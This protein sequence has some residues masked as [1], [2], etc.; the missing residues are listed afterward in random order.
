MYNMGKGGATQ[1]ELCC[2]LGDHTHGMSNALCSGWDSLPSKSYKQN[3]LYTEQ[4]K[5]RIAFAS[6]HHYI[7]D[8]AFGAVGKGPI[9]AHCD[10]RPTQSHSAKPANG[11]TESK[12]KEVPE[13]QSSLKHSFSLLSVHDFQGLLGEATLYPGLLSEDGINATGSTNIIIHK[14]FTFEGCPY[15]GI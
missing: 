8:A 2:S 5:K 14:S 1:G 15:H 9:E 10:G 3:H 4:G 7:I 13:S 11:S 6:V 12:G